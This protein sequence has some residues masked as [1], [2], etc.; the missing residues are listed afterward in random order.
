MGAYRS[1]NT[2]TIYEERS[3]FVWIHTIGRFELRSLRPCDL[4]ERHEPPL[5]QS[6][7]VN[8]GLRHNDRLVACYQLYIP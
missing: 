3:A 8:I 7:P 2:P 6:L 4:R 5:R 1:I